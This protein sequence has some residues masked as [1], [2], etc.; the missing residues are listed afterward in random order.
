MRIKELELKNFRCFEHMSLMLHSNMNVM[1]GVI[2]TG[3]TT[4]LEAIRIFIG[5]VFCELDKIE[6]K[7]SS[8][9]ITD[10]D[11]RLHNLQRQYS[12]EIQG[13]GF[14]QKVKT[15]KNIIQITPSRFL[16]ST[17]NV[18]KKKINE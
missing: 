10:D 1:V 3:K 6:N 12:V 2:G 5:A 11:V 18:N 9:S 16:G 13:L 14:S 4:I 17:L 7:I 15:S 8:P